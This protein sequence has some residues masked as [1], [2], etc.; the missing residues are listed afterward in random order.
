MAVPGRRGAEGVDQLRLGD[1]GRHRLV[2]AGDAL[3]DLDLL[4]GR[5]HDL[6][7]ALDIVEVLYRPVRG[8]EGLRLL[9]HHVLVEAVDGDELAPSLDAGE[10]FQRFRPVSAG[11]DR[12]PGVEGGGECLVGGLEGKPGEP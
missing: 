9:E 6:V 7:R 3:E 5:L 11:A 8:G 10:Q 2:D 4:L 1:G 12:E